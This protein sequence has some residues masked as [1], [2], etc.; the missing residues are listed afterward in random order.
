MNNGTPPFRADHVGSLLRPAEL[1]RARE[2]RQQE[3]ISAEALREIEDRSIRDVAKLQEEIGLQGIT[4]GEYRRTIWHADFL[5]QIDG[6]SV[7]EGVADGEGVAR[8][9]QS[10]GQEIDRSPTRFY[11]T[12]P[13]RRS[14]GIETENYKYLASVTSRTPK[15]CIPSPTILHMRGGRDAVDSK[16]YPDMDRFFSDLAQVY[17][18]EIRGLAE[19]GCTYLQLDDPNM[20][21]LCDEKMRENVSRIGEDPNELPRSYAKL[22]NDCIADRPGNMTVCMHICR[23]N[24]RSAWAAEGGYDPVAEILFNEFKLDGFFLEYDSP[25]AGSFSPL[26]FVPKDKQ[27]VLGLVTTKTG[28]WKPPSNS[29][30]A[31]TKRP[32]T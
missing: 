3:S 11:T 27:I 9:F 6:V 29:N 8:R 22:I 1:L 21:Y 17:R 4:D 7:K 15:L 31:S 23:G 32:A 26:R 25:R 10:G 14:H 30:G 13:L 19:L 2:Q 28:E 20:A 18:Q 16:A 12:G 5:R 24:F